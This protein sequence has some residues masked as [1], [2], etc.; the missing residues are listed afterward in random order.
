MIDGTNIGKIASPCTQAGDPP[1]GESQIQRDAQA[2]RQQE[3]GADPGGPQ[4]RIEVVQRIAVGEEEV[5]GLQRK[6]LRP[7]GRR[8]MPHRLEYGRDDGPD[9][10]PADQEN[11]RR[12]Q[13]RPM[14]LPLPLGRAAP[15]GRWPWCCGRRAV[16]APPSGSLRAVHVRR[17]VAI[18]AVVDR[19]LPGPAREHRDRVRD[20]VLV[21]LVQRP[22]RRMS[23]L[24]PGKPPSSVRMATAISPA[25]QE[26][27]ELQRGF[28]VGAV[29]EHHRTGEAA[30][31]A[32]VAAA[33][34]A[35]SS[36][37]ARRSRSPAAPDRTRPGS[38]SP[39]TAPA[40]AP[41]GCCPRYRRPSSNSEGARSFS[42]AH[43][44][45]SVVLGEFSSCSC[46]R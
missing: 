43:A 1:L 12:D 11:R 45:S 34:P 31:E 18:P 7:A 8:G 29:R 37:A 19:R 33:A 5:V 9:D 44:G 28:L 24:T 42:I 30:G 22:D 40:A 2:D 4:R 21:L 46:R 39:P 26:I 36:R 3:S 16:M 17:D 41:T 23:Q 32:E 25:Q 6:L 14:G 20:H 27:G 38:S 13:R 15:T 35:R 10:Q